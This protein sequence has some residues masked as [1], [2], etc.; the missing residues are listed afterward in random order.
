MAKFDSHPK[1]Q[2]WSAKN[3]KLPREV[4]LNSHKKFWFNCDKCSHEFEVSL[5]NVNQS[6][7]WCPYCYNRKLCGN[8]EECFNKSFASH[9]KAFCWANE[10]ELSSKFVLKGSEKMCLFN[11]DKCK[12]KFKMMPKSI[13]SKGQFCQYCAHQ[14]LCED[15]NCNLCFNN[16]FA[17]VERSKYLVNKNINPR[18]LFKSSSKKYQFICNECNE[19]FN[20]ILSD[21]TNGVWCPKC[22]NKTEKMVFK[23]LKSKYINVKH[24][25]KPE[26][27]RNDK[28]NKLLPFDIVLDDNKIIV[29][30]D[31]R[32][33]IEQVANWRTPED[34]R[35]ID[36]FKIK[37]ANENGYSVIRILQ[38]DIYKNKYNW[39]KELNENIQKICDEC[40]IQNIY[41]CKN[42]EYKDFVI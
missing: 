2:F 40:K 37:K 17:S 27:S 15:V 16:S 23:L 36:L 33:H 29:E 3:D 11:C 8:C 21:I 18:M 38:T 20:T 24:Q 7:N 31:G 10:N 12:H 32:Q 26:W 5:L 13:T 41:M 42:N 34:T 39:E 35:V 1:A 19:P 22:Y 28:T 14:K 30:T 25:F 6:N 9:S 4:A